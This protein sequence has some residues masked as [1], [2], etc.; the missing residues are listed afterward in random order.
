MIPSYQPHGS[1]GTTST[2]A[3]TKRTRSAS[4]YRA[5]REEN[6]R[7]RYQGRAHVHHHKCWLW[8][9]GVQRCSLGPRITACFAEGQGYFGARQVRGIFPRRHLAVEDPGFLGGAEAA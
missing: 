3:M 9:G 6:T 1:V 4:D 7:G 5:T 2:Q 8:M